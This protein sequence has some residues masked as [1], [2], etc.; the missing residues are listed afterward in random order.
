MDG[1]KELLAPAYRADGTISG[2]VD[3]PARGPKE[4]RSIVP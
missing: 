4:A 3:D 1:L 2:C